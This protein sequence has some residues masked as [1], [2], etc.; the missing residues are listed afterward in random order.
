M[1]E[2]DL[3][4]AAAFSAPAAVW[5]CHPVKSPQVQDAYREMVH[6]DSSEAQGAGDQ[7]PTQLL[8]IFE[9]IH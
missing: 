3:Y 9:L 1:K 7:F 4:K 2:N 8:G 6:E 5:L